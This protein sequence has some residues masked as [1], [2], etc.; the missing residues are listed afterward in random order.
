V[1]DIDQASILGSVEL[2]NNCW[3]IQKR[4]RAPKTF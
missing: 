1:F 3:L 2:Q 4:D